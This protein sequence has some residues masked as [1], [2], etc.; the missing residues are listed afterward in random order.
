[1]NKAYRAESAIEGHR[2]LT[3]GTNEGDAKMTTAKTDVVIG[4]S[5]YI[6]ADADKIV[7]VCHDRRVEV[8]LGG[9]V[10]RGDDLA[11]AADGKAVK[12]A[13]A[14]TGENATPA[15][16]VVA[17]ALNDGVAGDIISVLMK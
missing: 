13:A 16:K 8:Q 11:A 5:E 7:D 14:T 10:T 6:G 15:D 4:V 17:V 2:L 9:T 3:F 12:A 1:M